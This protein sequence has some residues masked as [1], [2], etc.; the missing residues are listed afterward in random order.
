MLV[1][2]WPFNPYSYPVSW[3]WLV[4]LSQMRKQMLRE[5]KWPIWGDTVNQQHGWA[6]CLVFLKPK[7][8]LTLPCPTPPRSVLAWKSPGRCSPRGS[9][10]V[11][12]GL[13][14]FDLLLLSAG[15]K[16]AW[17]LVHW[18]VR[19]FT[20]AQLQNRCHPLPIILSRNLPPK[21]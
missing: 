4:L 21:L 11:A 19:G 8:K 3:I 9:S 20:P 7:S 14:W 1:F 13:K 5:V 17:W 2:T 15:G 18:I 12:L 6:F 16:N 10:Q